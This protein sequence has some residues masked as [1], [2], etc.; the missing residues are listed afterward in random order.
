MDHGSR[1]VVVVGMFRDGGQGAF[2]PEVLCRVQYLRGSLD[3][4]ALR[5]CMSPCTVAV[6]NIRKMSHRQGRVP[7]YRQPCKILVETKKGIQHPWG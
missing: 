1:I 3:K 5:P 2:Y 7:E 4:S 6:D